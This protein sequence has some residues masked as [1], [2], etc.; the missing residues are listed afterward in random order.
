VLSMGK[1]ETSSGIEEASVLLDAQASISFR[2]TMTKAHQV[3]RKVVVRSCRSR[4]DL[5]YAAF[6]EYADIKTNPKLKRPVDARST[7]PNKQSVLFKLL[8]RCAIIYTFLRFPHFSISSPKRAGRYYVSIKDI[9]HD[10]LSTRS[11]LS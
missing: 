1:L 9:E 8:S 7:Y 5:S 6:R 2:T 3:E 11:P 10:V 4:C